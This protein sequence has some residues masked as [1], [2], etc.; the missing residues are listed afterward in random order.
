MNLWMQ[1]C[2]WDFWA[3][4]SS[5][6]WFSG[7]QRL[8][9]RHTNLQFNPLLPSLIYGLEGCSKLVPMPWPQR[10]TVLLLVSLHPSAGAEA[11]DDTPSWAVPLLPSCVSSHTHLWTPPTHHPPWSALCSTSF[12]LLFL[13]SS[14]HFHFFQLEQ[15][16]ITTKRSISHQCHQKKIK[17]G[18]GAILRNKPWFYP[19]IF[20]IR[21]QVKNLK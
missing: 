13:S 16:V 10:A 7:S 6:F 1:K 11:E 18:L 17:V 3:S 4:P 5:R 15:S 8:Q 12:H 19:H 9:K 14:F 20:A 21:F 2:S